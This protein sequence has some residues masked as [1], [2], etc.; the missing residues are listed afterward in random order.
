MNLSPDSSAAALLG[1]GTAAA[2]LWRRRAAARKPRV[3]G[4]VSQIFVYPIK[5]CAGHEVPAAAAQQSGLQ[6]DRRWMIV[7]LPRSESEGQEEEEVPSFVTQR[8]VPALALLQ[9]SVRC[10]HGRSVGERG[11][12]LPG[13]AASSPH[14]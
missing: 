7:R 13:T 3:I 10:T 12:S 8:E 9:P 1:L 2:L 11:K 14:G 5:G 6:F 4:A